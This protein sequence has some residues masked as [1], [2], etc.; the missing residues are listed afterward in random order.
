MQLDSI[1]QKPA[2]TM[3]SF[4]AMICNGL[5]IIGVYEF[6][7]HQAGIIEWS[8]YQSK[9]V[10]FFASAL[11]LGYCA[12]LFVVHHFKLHP[13]LITIASIL[14]LFY[15]NSVLQYVVSEV[16]IIG[17]SVIV[18]LITLSQFS[19]AKDASLAAMLICLLNV[20]ILIELSTIV[21]LGVH[22]MMGSVAVLY[23]LNKQWKI[24]HHIFMFVIC[25]SG[26]FY[27]LATLVDG[28]RFDVV[29]CVLFTALYVWTYRKIKAK[30]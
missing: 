13:V 26:L 20:S 12:Y 14:T 16:S 17:F 30:R 6:S 3:W 28:T 19:R 2:T 10:Y 29:L 11:L 27:F 21:N 8:R 9:Y 4:I 24:T 15:G 22:I 18:L 1:S 23:A 7:E 25:G 5:F